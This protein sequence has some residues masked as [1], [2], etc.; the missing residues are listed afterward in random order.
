MAFEA[1]SLP[2]VDLADLNGSVKFSFVGGSY[3]IRFS[4]A[5]IAKL[6]AMH[7]ESFLDKVSDAL[8]K[9]DIN[10]VCEI[11]SVATGLPRHDIMAASPPILPAVSA[12][13]LAWAVAW[14]GSSEQTPGTDE[15]PEGEEAGK[16]RNGL[17]TL[18]MRLV[19]IVLGP[20]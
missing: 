13:A 9:K 7:G 11:L 14:R 3:D 12:L 5:A 4:W 16:K 15:K 18:W 6:Q 20:G 2:R 19:R 8:D 10:S 17:L 1:Q